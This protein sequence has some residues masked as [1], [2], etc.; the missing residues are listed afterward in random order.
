VTAGPGNDWI[1]GGS[2]SDTYLFSRDQGFDSLNELENPTDT[3]TVRFADSIAPADLALF[4]SGTSALIQ[5]SST[6]DYL[7]IGDQF[8]GY[9]TV[10]RFVFSDGTT[11]SAAEFNVLSHM[12]AGTLGNDSLIGTSGDDVIYGLEGNDYIFAGS[13]NDTVLSGP[14]D[15]MVSANSGSDVLITGAGMIM[16]RPKGSA[17][18][19]IW[20]LATTVRTRPE[21]RSWLGKKERT[22]FPFLGMATLF[23]STGEMAL[24]KCGRTRTSA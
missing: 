5:I 7:Q 22:T 3:D 15:D 6:G 19:S 12:T 14:G 17:V 10:E 8:A 4:R 18:L 21:E 11:W 24:M 2:G 9:P 16:P 13:G 23:C 1:D 20:A